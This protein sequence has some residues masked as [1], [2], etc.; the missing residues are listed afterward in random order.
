MQLDIIDLDSAPFEETFRLQEEL[1][2]KRK[3]GE[4]SDTLI[5]VEH[6]PVYTLGRNADPANV[7]Q[8]EKELQA[9]GIELIQ[10]TRGGQV[11]YHGPGQLVGYPIINLKEHGLSVLRYVELLEKML[12]DTIRE[13]GVESEGG[14]KDRGVWIG[15]EKI[16]AL[17]VRITRHVTMHGFALN[18]CVN[19]DDYSGIIPCGI[20]DGG[21]TSLHRFIANITVAG[22]KPIL[23]DCFRQT[24]GS[25]KQTAGRVHS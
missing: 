7:L 21:V 17:G 24:F 13:F 16:A 14:R 18:V 4:I 23:I 20:R 11:T 19:L 6:P 22:L 10:T 8:S 25:S 12:I 1:V 2:Q 9:R 3:A 15:R 5:L